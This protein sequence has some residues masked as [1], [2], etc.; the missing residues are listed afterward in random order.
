MSER[1][2]LRP[3]YEW[4]CEACGRDNFTRGLVREMSPEDLYQLRIE[5][6][7]EEC[8]IG[9]FVCVPP[10]VKC[11]GCGSEFPASITGDDRDNTDDQENAE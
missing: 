1:V 11:Q 2:E 5:Y 7:V 6:G 10:T 3:A 4:T 9:N 8:A